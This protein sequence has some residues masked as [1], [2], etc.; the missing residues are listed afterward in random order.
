MKIIQ[1]GPVFEFASS[2]LMSFDLPCDSF[3]KVAPSS[4]SWP[5]AYVHKDTP[6]P[7]NIWA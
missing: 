6:R 7:A 5:P 4:A 2:P 3:T 1:V